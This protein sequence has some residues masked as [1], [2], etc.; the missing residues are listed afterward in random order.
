MYELLFAEWPLVSVGTT[1]RTL[2][3]RITEHE[4]DIKK[5]KT[6]AAFA[7]HT[8]EMG[9]SADFA[10]TKILDRERKLVRR[11]VPGP[12]YAKKKKEER[13]L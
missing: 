1:K 9:R 12:V 3:T 13:R 7:Q 11:F 5:Q 6:N 2:V 8:L 10:K 4:A